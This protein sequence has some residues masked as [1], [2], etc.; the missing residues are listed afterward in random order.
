MQDHQ[1]AL[2]ESDLSRARKNALRSVS[3][4]VKVTGRIVE[5]TSSA[6]KRDRHI[7]LAQAIAERLW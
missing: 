7:D 4:G 1:Q 3:E 5:H 2:S 6:S